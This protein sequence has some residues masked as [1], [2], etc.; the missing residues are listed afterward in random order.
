MR[1]VNRPI[2]LFVAI[3]RRC[4]FQLIKSPLYSSPEHSGS[5]PAC[6]RYPTHSEGSRARMNE[7]MRLFSLLNVRSGALRTMFS[8]D[9]IP[10]YW[11][12]VGSNTS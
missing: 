10:T 3:D 9:G 5:E 4:P 8:M 7:P 2:L 11:A 1:S 6:L 12:E